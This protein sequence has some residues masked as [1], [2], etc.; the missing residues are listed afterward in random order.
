MVKLPTFEGLFKFPASVCLIMC[1]VQGVHYV[2]LRKTGV[3]CEAV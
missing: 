3:S 1:N 2:T